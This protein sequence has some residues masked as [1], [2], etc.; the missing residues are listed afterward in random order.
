VANGTPTALTYNTVDRLWPQ[1]RTLRGLAAEFDG[2]TARVNIGSNPDLDTLLE[3]TVSGWLYC[4]S[5]GGGS[6]GKIFFKGW[7]TSAVRFEVSWDAGAYV[8]LYARVMA[9]TTPAESSKTA[10]LEK[11]EWHH[12]AMVYSDSGDRKAHIFLD[13]TELTGYAVHTAAVGA[14]TSDAVDNA[15]IGNIDD[16]SRGFDGLMTS[17]LIHQQALSLSRI[18]W[19]SHDLY[20]TQPPQLCVDVWER[21]RTVSPNK[22]PAGI[23]VFQFDD[24][25][26]SI[27]LAA[28]TT[29]QQF[30]KQ[31]VAAIITDDINAPGR[32]TAAQIATLRQRGWD[33]ASHSKSHVDPQG[34]TEAQLRT[35]LLASRTA[36]EAIVGHVAH[37]A[38]PF[39]AP[40]EYFRQV[41]ADYYDSAADSGLYEYATFNSFAIG[42]MT[43]DDPAGLVGYKAAMDAAKAGKY[44]LTF[45]MHDVTG[46]DQGTLEQLLTYAEAIGIPVLTRSEALTKTTTVCPFELNGRASLRCKNN[47]ATPL[48]VRHWGFVTPLTGYVTFDAYTDGGIIDATVVKPYLTGAGINQLTEFNY[49]PRGQGRWLCWSPYSFGNQLLHLGAE[50]MAGKTV[51][52]S[53]PAATPTP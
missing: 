20:H 18:Q 4:H 7:T 21:W 14:R 53:L 42:H 52:I 3:F 32:M 2:A 25:Y 43:I 29:F 31:A 33:I 46:P 9:A 45:I 23:L 47:A 38:W 50:I 41:C 12:V 35:E 37:Y 1:G 36:L 11:N 51:Y 6:A 16:G 28:G 34:L 26:D 49:T 8:G 44:M 27:F 10:C 17:V 13:G 24:G 39:A 40:N 15:I 48:P 30:G 5:L 19:L 22:A